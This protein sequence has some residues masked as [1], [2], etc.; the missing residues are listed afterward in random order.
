LKNILLSYVLIHFIAFQAWSQCPTIDFSIQASACKNESLKIKNTSTPVASEFNWDFC[1]G[2]IANTP[3]SSVQSISSN[4]DPYDIK[5]IEEN[6]LLYSFTINF[7][8]GKLVKIYFGSSIYNTPVITDLG[9]FGIIDQPLGL[10]FWNEGANK[11]G[12][13]S[14]NTGNVYL[15]DFGTSVNNIPTVTTVAGVSGLTNHRQIR[16]VQEPGHILAL[17]A[18]GN[19]NRLSILDFGSSIKNTPSIFSINVTGSSLLLGVDFIRYCNKSFVLMS[20]FGS[21]LHSLN[22]GSSLFNTPVITQCSSVGSLMGLTILRSKENFYAMVSSQAQGVFRFNFG[23][24]MN[25]SS[26]TSN[27]LGTFSALTFSLGFTTVKFNSKY[28]SLS[29][30]LDNNKLTTIAFPKDCEI[31]S[32]YQNVVSPEVSYGSSGTFTVSLTQKGAYSEENTLSKDISVQNIQA[33]ALS[34]VNDNS[35]VSSEITFTGTDN[36]A[37]PLTSIQW[38][39]G[40]GATATGQAAVHQY[41]AV[42]SYPLILSATGGNGCSNRITQNISIFNPPIADFEV[43]TANPI[44]SNQQYLFTNT[45]SFDVGAIP[46]YQ[47]KIDNVNVSTSTDLL[48]AFQNISDHQVD[49]VTTIPG[50]SVSTSKVISSITPGPLVDFS[51]TGSC[52]GDDFVFTNATQGNPDSYTWDFGDGQTSNELNPQHVF[53]SP[54]DHQ[55][56]LTALNSSSGCNN[57]VTK[58]ITIYSKPQ[59]NFT[60]ALPPFSCSGSASQFYDATPG[61]TD[62]NIQSWSWSFDDIE[63]GQNSSSQQNPQHT[64]ANAGDYNVSLTVTTDFNCSASI[65]K[66]VTI[67]QSPDATITNSAPCKDQTVQFNASKDGTKAWSWQIGNAFYFIGNPTYVFTSAGKRTI[68]LNVT[69]TNNCVSSSSKDVI[70]PGVLL[71]DFAVEKNCVGQNTKFTDVTSVTT[72]PVANELWTFTNTATGSG[73]PVTHAFANTGD[74]NINM[75]VISQAGCHYSITKKI[76]V[77]TSPVASF[78]ASPETGVPPLDVQFTNTSSNATSYEWAFN[79]EQQ[80]TTDETSPTFTFENLGDYVVDLTATNTQGCINTFSKI[81]RAALPVSDVSITTFSITENKSTGTLLCIATIKNNGNIDVNEVDLL[82]NISGSAVIREKIK[83]PILPGAIL[84]HPI[85]YEVLKTNQLNYICAEVEFADDTNAN[86]NKMCAQVNEDLFLF[87]PYPNPANDKLYIDWITP[88]PEDV[89]SVSIQ[90]SMGREV[91]SYNLSSTVGLNQA[92]IP[93]ESIN[94]GFYV[95]T[96]N[97]GSSKKVQR[98]V[99]SR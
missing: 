69:G 89:V 83:G 68:Y 74:Y 46:L 21:G 91:V 2:S 6:N 20:G 82:L 35:C 60:L 38:D 78:T 40:D 72:D 7:S 79:D 15:L 75:E 4:S 34:V 18:G 50:C 76:S 36:S 41:S 33:P 66:S 56:S 5:T 95:L 93:I 8:T 71:P 98:I 73:S 10:G 58:T 23:S 90:D 63:S 92:Y 39:F 32:S 59:P 49:L 24:D 67:A 17:I 84:N 64:Y 65:Q 37:A 19:T 51:S 81:V 52:F 53:G 28:Y 99:I 25:N 3:V 77:V 97:T 94:I 62:S 87:Q 86:N 54:G 61:P 55:I 26:P 43:P 9:N 27:L 1:D 88:K 47:W 16:I 13:I 11:Y 48:F 57:S 30:N 80:T 31:I 85:G 42:G 12:L 22:F 96:L 70:V 44:C 29:V 45:S 14:S